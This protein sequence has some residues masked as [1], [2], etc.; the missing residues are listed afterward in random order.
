MKLVNDMV[1]KFC[2]ASLL[3]FIL[4]KGQFDEITKREF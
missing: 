4:Y 3:V 2:S 1:E